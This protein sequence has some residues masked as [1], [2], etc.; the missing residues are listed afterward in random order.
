MEIEEL[1]DGKIRL[2]GKLWEVINYINQRD[3]LKGQCKPE[4]YK[5]MEIINSY[6]ENKNK[7]IKYT[8][9]KKRRIYSN[10]I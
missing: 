4:S 10:K 9:K 7:L 5:D 1:S 3:M 6:S 8:C 2:K